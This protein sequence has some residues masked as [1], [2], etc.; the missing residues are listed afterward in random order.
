M[1]MSSVATVIELK[2][3]SAEHDTSSGEEEIMVWEPNEFGEACSYIPGEEEIMVSDLSDM[4]SMHDLS[5]QIY[6]ILVF[7][8]WFISEDWSARSS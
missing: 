2:H 7:V 1:M 8:R 5:E 3:D 4:S 6:F